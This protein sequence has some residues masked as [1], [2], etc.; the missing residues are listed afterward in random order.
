MESTVSST[1]HLKMYSL[2]T[3]GGDFSLAHQV[4][5]TLVWLALLQIWID[6]KVLKPLWVVQH[7]R[8]MGFHYFLG[9]MYSIRQGKLI[10]GHLSLGYGHYS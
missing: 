4:D 7:S 3:S 5:W 6:K 8:T 2:A 10:G 1:I 9:F